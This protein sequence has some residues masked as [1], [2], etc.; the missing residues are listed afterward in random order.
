MISAASR[1]GLFQVSRDRTDHARGH[2][3]LQLEDIIESAIET[4]GRDMRPGGRVDQLRGDAHSARCP[5]KAA[6][7]HVAHAQ[8]AA[9]LPHVHCSVLVSKA[10]VA[11][12]DEEPANARQCRDDVLQDAVGEVF[13]LRVTAQVHEWQDGN[14]GPV[15]KSQSLCSRFIGYGSLDV[16]EFRS[17]CWRCFPHSA[18][19]PEALAGDR[20]D[21]A[22]LLAAVTDRL[23][24]RV[25][26]AGQSGFRD[27]PPAP[28]RLEQ[29]V[30]SSRHARG[31][32]PGR[33]ADR[34]P[35]P[36]ASGSRSL[37]HSPL[38]AGRVPV[39]S[40]MLVLGRISKPNSSG[41]QGR[42]KAFA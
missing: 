22:L 35:G 30:P 32:P 31:S 10:R 41:F 21:Q 1:N 27:D 8:V 2:L 14:R 9:D 6:F 26:V 28:H 24:H 16:R 39:S 4:V 25:D 17:A 13:L 3:I 5:A 12:D 15:G 34:R 19:E 37:R 7:Q 38:L 11:R 33:A 42:Y 36:L 20:S 23:A 18:D 40:S 29:I